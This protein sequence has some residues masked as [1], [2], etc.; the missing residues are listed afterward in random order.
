MKRIATK[1]IIFLLLGT[2]VN[3]AVAWGCALASEPE[4]W[5]FTHPDDWTGGLRQ[6]LRMR[7]LH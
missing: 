7:T 1:L 2:V 4:L 6:A 5:I 3:V